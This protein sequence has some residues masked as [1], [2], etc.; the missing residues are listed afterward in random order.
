[1]GRY[2]KL[3]GNTMIFAIGSFSSKL[4]VFFMLRYYTGMLTP[5]EFGISE[6]ITTTC[7][8]LMPF[9]MLSVNEAILRFA[10]DRTV[11]RA[12]VF[13]VG[14]K[15][16]LAGFI[17]FCVFSPLFLAID[18]LAPYTL[19]IYAYVL[20]GMLKSVCAQ[21]VRSLGYV[22][23][24]AFD[25][26]LATFTTIGLNI[27]FLSGLRWGLYGYV[28]SIIVSNVLSILFL[29]VVAQLW[30]FLDLAQSNRKLFREMLHYSVPLIPTTMFWWVVSASDRYMVTWFCGDTATGLLS[31]AHKIPSLLTIVS[32]IF[33]Q[34]W[35]IS[36]VSEAGQGKSTARFYSETYDYYVT[37]LFL[38]GSGIM[39][40]I[41]P[42]TRILYAPSYYE[43]WQ[44]VPFLVVGEVFSSLVTF[45]GSF[46]MVSKRNATLPVAICAGAI[47]N[48]GLN[49]VLIPR[50]GVLGA[51][52][53]TMVSYLVSFAIRAADIRRLVEL[54]LRP[55]STA[56]S[57]LLMMAQGA[58]LMRA[59]QHVLLIQLGMFLA[60]LL[61][62]LRA[63]I[64]LALGL[65][66]QLQNLR[67]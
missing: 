6:R 31:T 44:F 16:V 63:V 58:L 1:M 40:L 38:A 35:Q 9:V 27:L 39:M 57:F 53:A 43:S 15:T 47:V 48:V 22:R 55:L 28:S 51:S 12:Q 42:I 8:L 24:Y 54:D 2:G 21:F 65:L 59:T 3:V 7:N 10:M 41:Q 30:K 34:A 62:N 13:T 61:F 50:F 19:M 60:M 4:L 46:Y 36:A 29:F 52:F 14:I 5:A 64:R 25:G 26:F 56:V 18:M 37:L 17:I 33:Y 49:L 32:A 20:F 67:A 23:L 66:H 45:L 11:S